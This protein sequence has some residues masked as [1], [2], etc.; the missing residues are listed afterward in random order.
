MNWSSRFFTILGDKD[1][2]W[3]ERRV[4]ARGQKDD[5][6]AR[7]RERERE[8]ENVKDR[9]QKGKRHDVGP[10]GGEFIAF[11]DIAA[12]RVQ[13]DYNAAMARQASTRADH[14]SG[15]YRNRAHCPRTRVGSGTK[16]ERGR[17]SSP[18]NVIAV[19]CN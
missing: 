6:P 12:I 8:R 9:W 1:T 13:Y 10:V 14:V 16:R 5:I 4:W 11:A 3:N 17:A 18:A 7:A 2:T 15:L 19:R